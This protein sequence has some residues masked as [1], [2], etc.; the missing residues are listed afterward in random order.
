MLAHIWPYRV[1]LVRHVVTEQNCSHLV[2]PPFVCLAM[3]WGIS[4]LSTSAK[5]GT[6]FKATLT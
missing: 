3:P 1:A 6:I 4:L 5:V 2:T